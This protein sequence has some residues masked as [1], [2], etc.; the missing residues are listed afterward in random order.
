MYIFMHTVQNT[1]L[2]MSNNNESFLEGD[3]MFVV[4]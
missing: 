4:S 2:Y 3:K 1:S